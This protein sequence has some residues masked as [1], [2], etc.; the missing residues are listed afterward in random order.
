VTFQGAG[1]SVGGNFS[2]AT[3]E[4]IGAATFDSGMTFV[5]VAASTNTSVTFASAAR[6]DRGTV[7]FRGSLLGQTPAVG[8]GNVFFT[9]P[10]ALVGGGG[11]AGSTNVSIIPWAWGRASPTAASND[12]GNDFVTYGPGGVR[13]L[14][15]SEYATTIAPGVSTNNVR[16]TASTTVNSAST[17]NSLLMVHPSALPMT[18]SG[19]GILN[20]TS[21]AILN[22][23]GQASISTAVDFG[24]AEGIVHATS[25]FNMTGKI[26]GTNGLTKS[27]GGS[28]RL[29]N[30]TS[31]YTGTTTILSGDIQ[32][33]G[34]I[35]AGQPGPL[36]AGTGAIVLAAGGMSNPA[37]GGFA[38]LWAISNGTSTITRNLVVRGNP[39]GVA[40]LGTVF[41]DSGQV[42]VMSGNIDVQ[43]HLQFQGDQFS[44][45]IISGTISGPGRL[46]DGF[47]SSQ[48]LNGINTYTGG[49]EINDGQWI[50]GNGGALGSGTIWFNTVGGR[51]AAA[52]DDVS[53][54]NPVMFL[55]GPTINGTKSLSLG[56]APLD[57]A[58]LTLT[59][60]INNTATTT[61]NG[62]V[63][64]GGL[65]KAG[66]GTLR[67]ARANTYGGGTTLNE[68]RL[69][70]SRNT[71]L[72]SGSVVVNGGTLQLEQDWPTAFYI[73]GL[74]I[75][76]PG[77]VDVT[78]NDAAIDYAG[79][80][81]L[82]ALVQA[83]SDGRLFSS[84]SLPGQTTVG[85]AEASQLYP[86]GG[87]FHGVHVDST[88]VLLSHTF[89]G[90][91]DLDGDVD[92]GD[93][94]RLASNWQ[95]SAPWTS[96]DFDYNGTVDVNDLG[97][98]ASNW[99]AG[100]SGASG[101]ALSDTLI[102][103]GLPVSVPEPMLAATFAVFLHMG[104]SRRRNL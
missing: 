10:P 53:L 99:Q 84:T 74:T 97:L 90:D 64:N 96:G 86:S 27:A 62:E 73:G 69:I 98:L 11:P 87:T 89:A 48:Q 78:N 42:I 15:G 16:I 60:T 3:S 49:T 91:A 83:L 68:G 81:P 66:P 29:T 40:G 95:M 7:F 75:N 26:S 39:N 88:M 57:L 77:T 28:L 61:Y 32:F 24:S 79:A 94:G 19:T 6:G 33:L 72:G 5:T 70:A 18:I 36:G 63:F 12:A 21:G 20:I 8:V 17:I 55:A 23:A 13:P 92:V 41:S 2:V 38:R 51:L 31:D 71:S 59:H 46:S 80:T 1:L 85:V 93:L 76:A 25:L 35:L 50:V 56:F 102:A 54:T 37:A 104:A 47:A 4:S 45:M 103:L 82:P 100:V 44:P 30:S 52:V 43:T 9:T 34:S 67:L 14:A 65:I 22:L 58:G 101:A